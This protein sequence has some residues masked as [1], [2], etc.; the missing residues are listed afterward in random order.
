ML[1]KEEN[2][3][4][5]AYMKITQSDNQWLQ[6]VF[7]AA[8]SK[9]LAF[10]GIRVD[11]ILKELDIL[12]SDGDKWNFSGKIEQLKFIGEIIVKYPNKLELNAIVGSEIYL[13][14]ASKDAYINLKQTPNGKILTQIK[15]TDMPKSYEY[16]EDKGLILEIEQD[17]TSTEWLKVAYIPT[18]AKDTSKAICGVIHKSQVSLRCGE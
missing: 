17:F 16:K 9:P 7:N 1:A 4:D 5:S 11:G 13:S 18:E 3:P 2:M 10:V 15:K 8:K 14:Y 6:N 12:T